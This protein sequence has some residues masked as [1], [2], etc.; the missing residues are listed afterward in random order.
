MHG[1]CATLS[2]ST[3][4]Y[5]SLFRIG[6]RHYSVSRTI[7]T[8]KGPARPVLARINHHCKDVHK[9]KHTSTKPNK[10]T[11]PSKHDRNGRRRRLSRNRRH[12]R[13][14]DIV[15]GIVCCNH[16]CET[17]IIFRSRCAPTHL[18][19][20]RNTRTTTVTMVIL[21]MMMTTV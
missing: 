21:M 16:L 18:T 15:S 20:T 13:T 4:S 9:H 6:Q 3:S 11:I 10:R 8:C 2:S 14:V 5:L 7:I 19:T 1:R 12:A 17:V